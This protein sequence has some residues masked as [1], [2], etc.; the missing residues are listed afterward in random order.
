MGGLVFTGIYGLGKLF[1]GPI[2]GAKMLPP[3]MS[4][5]RGRCYVMS[6]L[7]IFNF[8]PHGLVICSAIF[9]YGVSIIHSDGGDGTDWPR[10]A[11]RAPC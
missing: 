7:V 1:R 5:F 9:G 2:L 4:F 6:I 8:Y 11:L 10:T 3:K